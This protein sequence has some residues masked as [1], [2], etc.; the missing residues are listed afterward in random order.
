VIR[1]E[2][3]E[4]RIEQTD[5]DRQPVHGA[6]DA[7]EVVALERP[8]LLERGA[9]RRL[10]AGHDHLADDRDP[11]GREEHVLGA[12]EPDTLGSELARAPGVEGRVGVGPHPK[13]FRPVA[14]CP[15]QE[16][17]DLVAQLARDRLHGI[18]DDLA[19]PTVDGDP[20][21]LPHDPAR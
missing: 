8:E 11:I 15:G 17:P 19:R 1:Q 5:R 6:E 4:R 3:V 14:I 7:D 16:L 9:P 12:D 10:V 2:L 13:P 18:E 21:A 20:V